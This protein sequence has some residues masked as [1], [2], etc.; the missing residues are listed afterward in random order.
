MVAVKKILRVIPSSQTQFENEVNLLMELKHQNIV[1]LVGYCYE[2]RHLHMLHE[3]KPVFA[4]DTESLLCLEC[5]PNGSLDKYISGMTFKK[6]TILVFLL[7]IF[8]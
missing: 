5:L 3:G 1:R 8:S 6:E 7:S 4:W 2:T